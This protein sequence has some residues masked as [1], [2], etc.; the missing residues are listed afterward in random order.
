MGQDEPRLDGTLAK[1]LVKLSEW[2]QMQRAQ[3]EHGLQIQ[4]L[5]FLRRNA[6]PE[7][8]YFAIPN[9]GKRSGTAGQR[10]QDEG[11]QRGVADLCIMLERGRAA[12]LELKSEKGRPTD[13]QVGFAAK[14][15]RLG[16]PHTI[17]YTLDEAIAFLRS[18]GALRRGS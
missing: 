4:V 17:A 12:W 10:M 13:E 2:Q 15:R 14:C 1:R 6:R 18:I 8:N 16:H 5:Q 3:T 9:A 7:I 11:L